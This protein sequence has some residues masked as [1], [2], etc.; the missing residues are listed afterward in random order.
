[1][2]AGLDERLALVAQLVRPA[3]CAADI[4]TDHGYLIAALCQSGRVARGY[5]CDLRP[6]PLA[7]AR[8]HIQAAGLSERI[9]TVCTDGLDG[10]PGAEIDEVIIAGM[11]G[12][13]IAQLVLRTPWLRDPAKHLVLQPMTK[14]EVL[15]RQLWEAGFAMA[16][17]HGA[18][19]GGRLYA[20]LS[21]FYA[22]AAYVPTPLECLTG[23]LAESSRPASRALLQKEA[24]RL[25]RVAQGLKKSDTMGINA[26]EYYCLADGIEALLARDKG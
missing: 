9:Q 12:E 18:Q 16:E 19:V 15:R 17:E 20:V 2:S 4:G 5:A 6:G 8:A 3:R 11:G 22:G 13:L 10:L 24:R 14:A 21:V 23:R 26:K 1:M 7:A 25:R